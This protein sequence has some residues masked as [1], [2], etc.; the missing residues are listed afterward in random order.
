LCNLGFSAARPLPTADETL[1]AARVDTEQASMAS[2]SAR[3]P[4]IS[5]H[6][7]STL[8]TSSVPDRLAQVAQLL[9][10]LE[11]QPS[12]GSRPSAVGTP[13]H[14][15]LPAAAIV[16][17]DPPHDAQQVVH[18][19][20][21]AAATNSLADQEPLASARLGIAGSLFQALRWKHEPTARHSL[22][23]ALL[24]SAWAQDLKLPE[25]ERDALELAALLHDIGKLGV[26][27]RILA[28]AG[29]LTP[30]EAA[31]MEGH[32]VI[33]REIV[34]KSCAEPLVLE[35]MRYAR[36]W[37][38]GSKGLADRRGEA[39]PRAARMIA[40]VDAFDS[41]LSEQ[42]Y[43]HALSQEHAFQELFHY[44]GTQFDPEL[45]RA[46]E[47][48]HS[49]DVLRAQQ[50]AARRWLYELD[51]AA[52]NA[53]W[54]LS[55]AV[56]EGE[57]S[58]GPSSFRL[59]CQ[60]RLL[61]N[62]YDG[63]MFVDA[64]LR[65]QFWNQAAVR[66]TGLPAEGVYQRVFVPSLIDLHDGSGRRLEDAECP[67][68]FAV[69]TGVQWLRRLALKGRGGRYMSVDAHAI[70]VCNR[71][72]IVIGLVLLMHDV[73]QEISL[74]ARCQD[75]HSLATRDP[76]TQVANRVEFENAYPR[77]IERHQESRL[78]LSVIV[79]DIDRFKSI[80]DNYG[81]QAGDA[82]LQS[83]ARLL[84]VSCREGDLVA[85]YGG[86]EFVLL[87]ADCDVA[88]AV[89]RAEELRLA[90]S[91][92][93]QPVLSGNTVTASFGVTQLQAGDTPETLFRRADRALLAAKQMGRNRVVQLGC[94]DA[95]LPTEPRRW[96]AFFRR[97]HN[98]ALLEQELTCEAPA[99]R[100][101]EK[102]RGFIA[103]HHARV[104]SVDGFR[105]HLL[106]DGRLPPAL[107]GAHDRTVRFCVTL[108][109]QEIEAPLERP[110]D[111]SG[112]P[113]PHWTRIHVA[114]TPQRNRERRREEALQRARH[115]LLSL[116]AYLMATAD[117]PPIEAGVLSRAR[118]LLGLWL[119]G[120]GG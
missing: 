119:H 8:A 110:R 4:G 70:P 2:S 34:C 88:A 78:P 113:A 29:P 12:N 28:K 9:L 64:E 85:R 108:R 83:F 51:P 90:F 114:I 22:R 7:G 30:Q 58:E 93:E 38:D 31:L 56:G 107:S 11:A 50:R 16:P 84:K 120:R 15:A 25:P 46:F 21:T 48:F 92:L 99:E 1:Y 19:A 36:A 42:P 116:R 74:E 94:G 33:G 13:V 87:W 86:E 104:V 60:Q 67:V 79:A 76:L 101:I 20:E 117:S 10:Q 68:A 111:P 63:V 6:G 37:Y 54:R 45:V 102:L 105:V 40:I 80:N 55:E 27:D 66:L 23:V 41:M 39:L 75:L 69:R 53:P 61:D 96:A 95:P 14:D 82:V 26:P 73:S 35:T 91:Q 44:A 115:L 97:P 72:G 65:I 71:E 32:W 47:T 57:L 77:F 100:C 5:A 112:G 103:D 52:A 109:L 49:G 59:L 62:M 81:H 43:R 89:R 3:E 24:C 98:N 17:A 18:T 106:V 118:T